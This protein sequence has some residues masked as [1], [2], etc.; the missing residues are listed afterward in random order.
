MK[1]SGPSKHMA[2]AWDA[3]Q[4]GIVLEVPKGNIENSHTFLGCEHNRYNKTDT[5]GKKNCVV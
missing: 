5:N 1:L 3:L 2:K 4:Q